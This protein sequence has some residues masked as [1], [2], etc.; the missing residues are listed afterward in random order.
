MTEA[1]KVDR[2]SGLH[3]YDSGSVSSGIYDPVFKASLK[4][5]REGTEKLLKLYL[6]DLMSRPEYTF[7]DAANIVSWAKEELGIEY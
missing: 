2:L 3:A 6:V 7:E 4:A 1:E 5:D